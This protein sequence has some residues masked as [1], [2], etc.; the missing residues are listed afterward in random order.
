MRRFFLSACLFAISAFV[1]AES[2]ARYALVI[3]NAAYDGEAALANAA[4]DAND[5]AA[6]LTSIGWKVTKLIDGGRKPHR[7]VLLRRSRGA[8]QRPEL[9]HPAQRNF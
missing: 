8:D 5:M 3:G 2:D 1:F 6:A 9:P 4:N 7:I